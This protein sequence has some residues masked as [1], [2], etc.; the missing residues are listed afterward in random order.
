MQEESY[1]LKASFWDKS[2]EYHFIGKRI[3]RGQYITADRHILNA[4]VT[5]ALNILSTSNVVATSVLYDRGDVDT[6]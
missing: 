2:K 3:H 1:T 4:D 6:Q 5:D